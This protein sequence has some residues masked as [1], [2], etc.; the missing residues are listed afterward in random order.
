MA[1]PPSP[2]PKSVLSPGAAIL[3][4]LWPGLGHISLGERKRGFLIMFGVLFLVL[5]G[6]LVGGLDCVDRKHD[7]LWFL[8]QSLC[9]PIA[10]VADLGNQAL[11]QPRQE[12]DWHRN[13]DLRERYLAQ[14]PEL[15]ESLR[16]VGLGRVNEMG[17]LFVALAGL[18]NLV[19]ILDA[20][21][22][23]PYAARRHEGAS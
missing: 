20:L 7:R 19:V 11:V 6:L 8:A 23:R 4:W 2:M 13:F 9:G 18:M 15:I 12:E 21:Y 22:A 14:D 5:S 3:A 16:R 17:T 10:L 1:D